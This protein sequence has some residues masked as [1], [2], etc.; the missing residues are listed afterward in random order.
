MK[1]TMCHGEK[2]FTER[3][4]KSVEHCDSPIEKDLFIS[5]LEL[6]EE[7]GDEIPA[8]LSQV[9]LYYDSKVQR[10]RTVKI[11]DHQCMDFLMLFSDSR[12]VVIELDGVQH[13]G[14]KSQIAGGMY[15]D[16]IASP[17]LY[18]QMVEAVF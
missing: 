5:Y 10:E 3:L 9:Y 11:F 1:I 8:L 7:L 15:P 4:W 13:Y 14:V 12:R 17:R 6:V 18:V 16:Y 2:S